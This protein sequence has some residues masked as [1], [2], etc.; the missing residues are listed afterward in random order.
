MDEFGGAP[1]LGPN[2]PSP[3]L[4][5]GLARP[6]NAIE[7][8]KMRKTISQDPKRAEDDRPRIPKMRRTI[9]QDPKDEEDD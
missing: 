3:E 7:F 6:Q 8:P 9:S 5:F 2:Q 1:K 4:H